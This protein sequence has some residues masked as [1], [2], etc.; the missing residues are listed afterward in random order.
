MVIELGTIGYET[1][2]KGVLGMLIRVK[3]S[4]VLWGDKCIGVGVCLRGDALEYYGF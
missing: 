3:G 1:D 4:V 2:F